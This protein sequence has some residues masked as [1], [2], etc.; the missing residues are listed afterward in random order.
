MKLDAGKWLLN[1]GVGL[2]FIG[3]GFVFYQQFLWFSVFAVTGLL[4]CY[5]GY[6]LRKPV[7]ESPSP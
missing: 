1:L 3:F 5:F 4:S 7:D 2:W 6:V